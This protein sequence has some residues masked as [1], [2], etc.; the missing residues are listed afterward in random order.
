MSDWTF[1]FDRFFRADVYKNAFGTDVLKSEKDSA[2]TQCHPP[3]IKVQEL[4]PIVLPKIQVRLLRS[5]LLLSRVALGRVLYVTRPTREN[6]FPERAPS[7]SY[8]DDPDVPIPYDV[9][10]ARVEKL[11]KHIFASN[12]Q[13]PR[14]ELDCLDC[15]L[16]QVAVRGLRGLVKHAGVKVPRRDYIPAAKRFLKVLENLRRRARRAAIKSLGKERYEKMAQRW[17]QFERDL[18]RSCINSGLH[19]TA[20]Y[21][22]VT[23]TPVASS[24]Y[25]RYREL[26]SEVVKIAE[27]ELKA[28]KLPVPESPLLRKWAR[29]LL[30]YVRRDREPNV[31]PNSLTTTPLG[32]TVIRLYMSKKVHQLM[33]KKVGR[34]QWEEEYQRIWER[35]IR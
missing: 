14:L 2:R 18:K 4:P 21:F 30:H 6:L 3:M 13:R 10:S 20:G 25:R 12:A 22:R 7:T 16:L 32:A 9:F 24:W 35:S 29:N 8:S 1:D 33:W 31:S 17:R 15:S 27:T 11:W 5:N 28:E 23:P 26:I 19:Y 34:Q